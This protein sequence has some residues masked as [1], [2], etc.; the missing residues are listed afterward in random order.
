MYLDATVGQQTVE[1]MGS[2]ISM[3]KDPSVGMDVALEVTLLMIVAGTLAGLA[4][5]RRAASVCPI[6]ALRAD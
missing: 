1:V 6:E 4:P 2:S 3:M 5:A